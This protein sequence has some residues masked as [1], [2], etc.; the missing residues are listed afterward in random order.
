MK[1]IIALI[2]AAVLCLSIVA[3]TGNGNN[4]AS[5]TVPAGTG[6]TTGADTT[7]ADTTGADTTAD[8]AADTQVP[9]SD[10]AAYYAAKFAEGKILPAAQTISMKIAMETEGTAFEMIVEGTDKMSKLAIGDCYIAAYVDDANAYVIT[11]ASEDGSVSAM[12]AALTE[13]FDG[14]ELLGMAEG[15]AGEAGD[16]SLEDV[17]SVEYVGTEEVDGKT[18]DIVNLIGEDS[19]L[20]AYIAD[21]KICM[22][23][24]EMEEDGEKANVEIR[25][26]NIDDT[27][28]DGI[29]FTDVDAETL[30]E[31]YSMGLLMIIMSMMPTEA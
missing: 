10:K 2:I 19:T 14:S 23:T 11:N 25:F 9:D 17:K 30:S 26:V 8:T 3:C 16:F 5:S 18:Y 31:T 21:D 28:P 27:I 6:D 22:A 1:R 29:T 13:E 7:G 24:M 15:L 20:K 12:K 4:E